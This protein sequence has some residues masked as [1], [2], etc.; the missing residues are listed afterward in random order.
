M[1]SCAIH[2]T[3]KTMNSLEYRLHCWRIAAGIL[4]EIWR[5]ESSCHLPYSLLWY[6]LNS[7][8]K[9]QVKIDVDY[10]QYLKYNAISELSIFCWVKVLESWHRAWLVF[11]QIIF[12]VAILNYS[13]EKSKIDCWIIYRRLSNLWKKNYHMQLEC[14]GMLFVRMQP[15]AFY[16][17]HVCL[18]I[19]PVHKL[20]V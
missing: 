1:E 13:I 17:P 14:W 16:I 19:T 20:G 2:H 6:L 18:K 8:V 9:F 10:L 4:S 15:V 3:Y 12:S 7:V 5:T 11:L